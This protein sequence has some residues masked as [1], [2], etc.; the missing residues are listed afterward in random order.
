VHCVDRRDP[1]AVAYFNRPKQ[2]APGPSIPSMLWKCSART[3]YG[4]RDYDL[5]QTA[6]R[7]RFGF[8][9]LKHGLTDADG[10]TFDDEAASAWI[11]I[12]ISR[13]F[14]LLRKI[15]SRRYARS[16]AS[17]GSGTKRNNY[18]ELP[19]HQGRLR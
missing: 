16:E 19:G 11:S 15:P 3:D 8:T 14:P 10:K 5:T 1:G 2:Q 9:R 4:C 17:A 7:D 12:A 6:G 18:C 13:H